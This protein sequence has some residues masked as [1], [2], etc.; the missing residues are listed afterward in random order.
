MGGNWRV[1]LSRASQKP[2]DQIWCLDITHLGL[3]EGFTYLVA[4]MD[5]FSRYV[6]AWELF[7]SMEN[8]FCVAALERALATRRQPEIH[9]T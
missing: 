6:I 8:A 3:P 9:N 5:W 1:A 4:I 7:N 2:T